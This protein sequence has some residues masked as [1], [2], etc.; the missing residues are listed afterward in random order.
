MPTDHTALHNENELFYSL[1]PELL[2]AL[3]RAAPLAPPG[4]YYEFGVFKGFSIWFAQQ[5]FDL[6]YPGKIDHY[7]GF[8]SFQGLPHSEV[9]QNPLWTPGNYSAAY[10]T[11]QQHIEH[12]HGDLSRLTLVKGF[13]DLPFLHSLDYNFEKAS[14]CVIDSDL[15]ESARDAL[16]FIRHSLQVGT[17]LLFDDYNAFN[18]S[19][20]HGERRAFREFQEHYPNVIFQSLFSIGHHGQCF[21]ITSL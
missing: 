8:D 15:Y 1:H 6:H 18:K 2:I 7:F 20:D 16:E 9:D 4:T 12:W 17:L 21:Q 19:P 3:T 11:V 14:V 13:F 10:E 5:Y